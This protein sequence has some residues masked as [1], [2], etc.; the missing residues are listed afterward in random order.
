MKLTPIDR[1]TLKRALARFETYLAPGTPARAA[2]DRIAASHAAFEARKEEGDNTRGDT[3][4]HRRAA[5]DLVASFGV[6]MI[7][8]EPAAAFS[9]DG[10]A[11]RTRSEASVLIHELAHW[12]ICPAPRRRLPDFGLGAGPETG[13]VAEADAARCATDAVKEHEELMASLLGILW[14]AALDQPA[15][16]AFIEQNWLEAWERP[17]AGEQFRRT[18][19]DL[20]SRGLIGAD[21]DPYSGSA[22]T[23][24]ISIRNA[25]QASAD[26]STIADAGPSLGK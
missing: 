7:D 9:W 23:A 22:A 25:G 12:Q 15:I 2:F 1:D 8:E 24:A 10:R 11:I 4:A 18:V 3:A 20:L 13:R 19:D 17:V 5:R 16:D 6:P 21:G 26:T 14:E